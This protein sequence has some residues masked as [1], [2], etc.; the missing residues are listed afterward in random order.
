MAQLVERET[1]DFGLG[2]DPG[3]LGSG[4]GLTP[5]TNLYK[6]IIIT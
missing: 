6:I 1:L 5:L 2:E 3:V 4:P